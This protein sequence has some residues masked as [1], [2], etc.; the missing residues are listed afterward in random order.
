M[1]SNIV[2]MTLTNESIIFTAE[3]I[4]I[5]PIN[6]DGFWFSGSPTELISIMIFHVDLDINN[7][8]FYVREHECGFC[9]GKCTGNHYISPSTDGY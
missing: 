2:R 5:Q 8:K 7:A 6:S 1:T 3:G 4:W 9:Q